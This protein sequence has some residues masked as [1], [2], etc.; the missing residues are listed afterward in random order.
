VG[1]DG[2]R[3]GDLVGVTGRLGG[4]GAGLA[5]LERQAAPEGPTAE[6]Q[7]APEGPTAP[8]GRPLAEGLSTS[9]G[10]VGLD[11]AVAGALTR[12]RHPV[13]RLAEGRALAASGAHAM[14]DL[15][16]GL[17]TDAGHIGRA[18]GVR[19]E[20][21]LGALPLEQGLPEVAAALGVPAWQLAAGAG[22]DYELCVCLAPAQRER[23]ERALRETGEVGI[24]WIGRV[25]RATTISPAGVVLL[26]DGRARELA[27][28]EHH[29]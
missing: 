23:A 14:I 11:A 10:R 19:L 21:D 17:G 12:L 18:S 4:A 13:P 29:W 25:A 24:T 26:E 2:A 16:D 5:V 22:E 3:V 8:E 6:R 28:F 27:G 20:I 7:A 15:S 1:R 9:A